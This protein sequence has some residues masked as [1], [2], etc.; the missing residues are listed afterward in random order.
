MR[1]AVLTGSSGLAEVYPSLTVLASPTIAT[2]CPGRI[3]GRIAR[4]RSARASGFGRILW[5]W[6]S[7][8]RR[9]ASTV[10]TTPPPAL[11]DGM[12]GLRCMRA[13]GGERA[14]MHLIF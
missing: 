3:V 11:P 12:L 1:L 5:R 2:G 4:L 8:G 10:Y 14:F 7:A 13:L 6:K 9:P